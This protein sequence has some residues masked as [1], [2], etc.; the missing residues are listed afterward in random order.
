MN[1][2]IGII[3]SSDGPTA[4]MVA[5]STGTKWLFGGLILLLAVGIFFLVL[6]HKKK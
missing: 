4:V 3:G 2:T 6:R 1:G 5:A